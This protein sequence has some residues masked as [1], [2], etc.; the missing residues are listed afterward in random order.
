MAKSAEQQWAEMNVAAFDQAVLGKVQT[1][2]SAM[3]SAEVE[4]DEI[5]TNVN[6]VPVKFREEGEYLVISV[7]E[8]SGGDALA[9]FRVP[10]VWLEG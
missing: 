1:V 8:A 4:A 6:G 9:S 7:G 5:R 10:S 2:R 3:T